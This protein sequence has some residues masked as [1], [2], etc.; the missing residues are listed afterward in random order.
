VQPIFAE[1]CYQCHGPTRQSGRVRWDTPAVLQRPN[2]IVPGNPDGSSLLTLIAPGSR[3][4]MPPA[5]QPQPD[6]GDI[7]ILRQ[8]IA[9]GAKWPVP[10]AS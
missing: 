10:P 5:N 6:A 3:S 1:Y 7:A 4:H 8:W 2:L 9:E